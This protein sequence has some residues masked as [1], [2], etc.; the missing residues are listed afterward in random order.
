MRLSIEDHSKFRVKPPAFL[1]D[2]NIR[3]HIV[4]PLSDQIVL[5][6]N[7]LRGNWESSMLVNL[8]SNKQAYRRA[9]HNVHVVMPSHSVASLKRNIFKNHDRVYDDRD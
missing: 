7:R 4:S 9:F 8:L 3:D 6:D 5:G 2:K 1:C